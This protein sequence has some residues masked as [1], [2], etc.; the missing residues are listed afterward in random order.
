MYLNPFILLFKVY[1]KW[2]ILEIYNTKKNSNLISTT[3]G[4]SNRDKTSNSTNDNKVA[5]K[6]I[7]LDQKKEGKS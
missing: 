1:R 3:G 7:V 5:N 2:I 4:T 6:A